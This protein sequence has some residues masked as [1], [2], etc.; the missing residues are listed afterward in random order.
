MELL[1]I[2]PGVLGALLLIAFVRTLVIKAPK[3]KAREVV[4]AQEQMDAYG[5]KLGDMIRVQ[6]VSKSEEE[7]LSQFYAYHKE[8]ERLFPNVHKTLDLMVLQGTLIYRWHG[9]DRERRPVLLMG[10][11]D[12]VP[13][14]D[15]GWQ[16][17]AYSGAV[18]DGKVFGR[19]ALDCKSTMFTQLQAIEELIEVGFEPSC[20]VYLE[21]SINEETGGAGAKNAMEYL[22]DQGITFGIVLDEGGAVIDKAVDG[23]DRPYAV[24][25][26]TE[27]GYMDVKITAQGKGGHSSTPPRN[28]PAAR[29][30]AFANEIEKKR[31]FR[32]KMLP[33][34]VKM[35]SRMAPAFP[36]GLRFILGNL[37]LFRPLVKVLMPAVSPFGEAIMATTCCFTMMEGSGAANVIPKE[38]YLIANLRTT[39]FQGCDASLAVLW[40]YAKK[41]DLKLEVLLRRDASPI[42][43]I[44][45]AE[46]AYL[47]GCIRQHF[48]GVGVT[49]FVIMGG[50]DCRHFHAL[51]ENALRFCPV[52]M[53]STQS[54]SCHAVDENVDIASLCEGVRFYKH[55]IENYKL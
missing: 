12:V 33:E 10:H 13:A 45:S 9:T 21:Y 51:S 43:N 35:L 17:P 27:K 54:A 37:W 28:T 2:L 7:D 50:T 19:G 52:P 30:F 5:Q 15:A 31:P 34:V 48:P 26:I 46:Y 42:S 49:P 39:S 36:F 3:Y 6:T 25:G 47:E 16:V 20:D 29:L 18:V 53:T 22:R 44:H 40:K 55:F 11:Q 23:M 4:F 14:T 24:V 41:Y 8:L 1:W 32:K 38:P